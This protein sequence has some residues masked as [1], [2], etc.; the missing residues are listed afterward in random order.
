MEKEKGERKKAKSKKQKFVS[1]RFCEPAK[2]NL[3][4]NN[5]D[6]KVGSKKQ[7]AKQPNLNYPDPQLRRREMFA[8]K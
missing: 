8:A 2:Q 6:C 5:P 4:A 1:N 3:I 7:K